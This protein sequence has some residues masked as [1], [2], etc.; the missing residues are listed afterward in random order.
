MCGGLGC[1]DRSVGLPKSTQGQCWLEG[2]AEKHLPAVHLLPP[3]A[4][5]WAGTYANSEQ[6]WGRAGLG[7]FPE[8]EPCQAAPAVSLFEGIG[9]YWQFPLPCPVTQPL[10][11]AVSFC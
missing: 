4:L 2:P 6:V 3:A 8:A 11:T 9:E 5:C 1:A 10:L 7:P